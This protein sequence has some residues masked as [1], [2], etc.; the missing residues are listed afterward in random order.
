MKS[1]CFVFKIILLALL[2]ANV[3]SSFGQQ[4]SSAQWMRRARFGILVHYLNTSQ[5]TKEP[6]N[7]GKQ[8]SW[9]SCVN[10]FDVNLFAEQMHE[11]GAGYVI[12]TVY[13]GTKY[14]CI[15]NKTY[16][17][18]TGYKRGE[19]TSNRD[20]VSDLYYALS[21]YKIRLMLYV[22]GD[23][24]YK[25]AQSYKAFQSPM[26][27]WVKN[28]NKFIVTDEWVNNWSK[29]LEDISLR[30]GKKVSGWWVDGAFSFHGYN[31]TSLA[32]LCKALKAGNSKSIIGFNA[33]PQDKV[34]FYS[35]WDDY[36]AGEMYPITSYPPQGGVINGVQWNVTTFLGSNWQNPDIRFSKEQVTNY[37]SKCNAAGGTVTLDVCL[38]RNGSIDSK[39]LAFLKQVK[40]DLR[41]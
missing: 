35:K 11:I 15:P 17:D 4:K 27:N 2:I 29:V 14:M 7:M 21:K 31:D 23:G 36:T 33:S 28:G 22:T 30:Y 25:D 12:F 8:T 19:A 37:I 18:I 41:K 16:E 38:L 24:T 6:W 26:L 13:Q 34:K 39:Q 10:D 1:K 32:V 3:S 40:K 5:N 20:L 9:D